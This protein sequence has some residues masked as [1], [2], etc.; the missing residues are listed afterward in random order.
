MNYR[1][2]NPV[3][4][5]YRDNWDR[6]FRRP[7]VSDALDRISSDIHEYV[8]KLASEKEYL[9]AT[10]M[11]EMGLKPSEIVLIVRDDRFYP[12]PREPKL[13]D[14]APE[15]RRLKDIIGDLRAQNA[16]LEKVVE[17]A[18]DVLAHLESSGELTSRQARLKRSLAALE[19][20]G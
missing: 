14:W 8:R 3:G 12:A 4:E 19:G 20:E 11:Q 10:Y 5:D 18:R 17:D 9:I 13:D 7:T 6:I 1:L 16:L 15:A 2:P